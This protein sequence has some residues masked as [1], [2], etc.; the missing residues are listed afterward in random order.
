M[1]NQ[2]SGLAGYNFY[3]L[4]LDGVTY[5]KLNSTP[6]AGGVAFPAIGL[7]PNTSYSGKL[8]TTSVDNAG[9][10]T[11]KVAYT[12]GAQ[13]LD[14]TPDEEPMSAPDTAAIDTIVANCM[15][16]GAGPGVTISIVSPKGYLTKSYGS[17]TTN[18]DHFRIASQTKSFTATAVLRAVDDGLLT[19]G[20]HLSDYLPGY[21][22]DP[23]IE[24]LLT[25]RSGI[26]DYQRNSSLAFNFVMNPAMAYTVDQIIALAKT[27]TVD[28]TDIS[29][30]DPGSKYYYTNS[31]YYLLG[32]I[33]EA[34]DPAHRTIDQ[35]I[36][37]DMLAPLGMVN[38][39]F[40]LGTGVPLTPYSIGYAN[41]PILAI[42]GIILRQDVSNQNSAF[43]WAAGSMISVISDM[44]MWGKE[45]RDG[46]LLS[47]EMQAL[48]MTTYG[49]SVPIAAGSEWGL[50]HAGPSH[51]DYGLGFLRVGSW[52][53][54]DGSWLGH[55]SCTMF[56]PHTGTI[57]SVY[58][59]FQT[60]SLLALA[61]IWY[62]I[63]QYLYPGSA[64]YPDYGEGAAESG[65]IAS[66]L[67]APRTSMTDAIPPLQ[68]IGANAATTTSV[69]I[70]AHQAGDLIVLHAFHANDGSQPTA[71][72]PA[73]PVPAWVDIDAP[74]F[75]G[76][77][78]NSRT[79]Q[80]KATD[81]NHISGVW[82]G[83]SVMVAAVLRGQHPSAP[84]GG[85]ATVLSSN[86]TATAPAVTMT[87]TDGTSI[88]LEFH[89][90]NNVGA[91]PGWSA[92]PAGYTRRAAAS[93][94]D[95]PGSVLNTKNSTTSDGA[96]DQIKVG[97]FVANHG[98][99]V[100]IVGWA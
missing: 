46:T 79:A 77:G 17:G 96:V 48:R 50:N 64:N 19:L 71:P 36:D 2:V 39:Y 31:N 47:P 70:P 40:Q 22:C 18:D 81:N 45:L 55:D 16:A 92:A 72:T 100:E 93:A 59:N 73:G 58:E 4:N 9:N 26:Y 74:P 15:A 97:S 82:P 61:T 54:H 49:P 44:V 23:T 68:F 20:D 86:T 98:A 78:C 84:I 52:F 12:T 24:E 41:N 42:I 83:A 1:A 53:G 91:S 85:H 11:A 76:G 37:Q 63:A 66:S 32:R 35:I 89:S 80:F 30:F 88:L 60:P 33:A 94:N 8:F 90:T 67:M 3:A 7:T 14:P 65:T 43:V 34:V 69:P 56:E 99:T 5:T 51:F 62:E 38:T 25:M 21:A 13:T 57:I 29:E 28:R 27:G 10:E 87:R 95:S 6:I 75:T